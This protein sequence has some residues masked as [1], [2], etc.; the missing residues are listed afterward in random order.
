MTF[1]HRSSPPIAH[2]DLKIENLLIDPSG[3]IKL[4]DFGSATTDTYSPDESW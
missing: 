1:L 3:K 2:R 4:C